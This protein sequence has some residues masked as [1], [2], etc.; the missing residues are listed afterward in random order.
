[1]IK[2]LSYNLKINIETKMLKL[3]SSA[4][5]RKP[6]GGYYPSGNHLLTSIGMGFVHNSV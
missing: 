2:R 3:H 1:M 6:Y 4:K 5:V